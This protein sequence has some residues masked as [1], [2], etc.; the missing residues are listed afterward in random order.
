M[1]DKV[2]APFLEGATACSRTGSRMAAT[3]LSCGRRTPEPRDHRAR[4]RDRERAPQRALPGGVLEPGWGGT[5]SSA[6]CA[7]PATS[8]R[9]S[10]SRTGTPSRRS[11]RRSADCLLRN[12]LS[13][14]P[15]DAGLI[16]C[17]DDRGDPVVQLSPPLVAPA[18]TSTS[19]TTSSTGCSTRPGPRCI[20]IATAR[21]RQGGLTAVT[22][23]AR[24]PAGPHRKTAASRAAA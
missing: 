2:A 13:P 20:R 21:S 17:A 3:R 8:A 12:F 14:G 1:T 4:G 22:V 24:R 19:S 16:C 23:W 6:T 7:A 10:W 18:R 15:Y 5:R 9:W 11:R